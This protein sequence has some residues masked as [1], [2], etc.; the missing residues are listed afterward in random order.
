MSE[1]I[2]VED[3][4]PD[5]EQIVIVHAPNESEPVW[6]GYWDDEDETWRLVEGGRLSEVTHWQPLPDEPRW[7]PIKGAEQRKH[8]S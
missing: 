5:A 3:Q 4:Y 8:G 6:L 1:W 7:E 2:D